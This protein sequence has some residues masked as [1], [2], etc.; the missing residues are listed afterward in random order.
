MMDGIEKTMQEET[1][2]ARLNAERHWQTHG[3]SPE[4]AKHALRTIKLQQRRIQE[5]EDEVAVLSKLNNNQGPVV[6][7]IIQ[8]D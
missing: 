8:A 5:L 7:K 6:V 4:N 1:Q 3:M 2:K